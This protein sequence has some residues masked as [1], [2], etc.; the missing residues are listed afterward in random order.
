[1]EDKKYICYPIYES[2][3]EVQAEIYS[4][5]KNLGYDIRGEVSTNYNARFD[6]VVFENQTARCLIEVKKNRMIENIPK[7]RSN[8]YR[9][10]QF[11]KYSNFGIPLIY[12]FGKSEIPSCI[13][14]VVKIMQDKL[15][16]D[17][18]IEAIEPDKPYEPELN[19]DEDF[20]SEI[21]Y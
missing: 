5:L 14:K 17:S 4:I 8:L 9:R 20:Y 7:R 15:Y 2:E 18:F 11:K 3:F 10:K 19:L 1:M 16:A 21:N 12:C 13:D 6:L